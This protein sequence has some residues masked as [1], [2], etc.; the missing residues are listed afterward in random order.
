MNRRQFLKHA[1]MVPALPALSPLIAKTPAHPKTAGAAGARAAFRRVRPSDPGW[2]TAAQWDALKS[3]V[4]GRLISVTDPFAPCKT[5]PASSAACVD[6]MAELKNPFWLSETPGATQSAGWL[7]A[8]TSAPSVYAVA[9]RSAQDVAAAVNFAREHRLRFVVKGGGHSY[10]G[11]SNAPDSLLIWTHEMRAITLHDAFTPQGCPSAQKAVTIEAGAR[12]IEAYD[13]VTTKAG[14]YVQGGG[15]TTVGVVGLV[16]GGGFGSFSKHFGMA[17]ASLLEAEVVTADGQIRVANACTNPDLFW[18]LKGGGG[19]TF[20]VVTKITLAT[21]DLPE[22]AGG[23]SGA[24]KVKSDAAMKRLIEWF[25]PFAAK[26]LVNANWGESVKFDKD[27]ME[28]GMVSI[29]LSHEAT[30]AAWKPLQDFVAAAP[31]DYEWAEKIGGGATQ[32]R[33]WWDVDWRNKYTPGEFVPDPRPNM[34]KTNVVWKGDAPQATLFLYAY[35]S[36]WLPA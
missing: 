16:T 33:N 9:A 27:T 34:P 23:A 11:N 22:F 14:R 26:T 25:L 32:A 4:G 12:W 15:C 6:R 8:W 17:A 36:M 20:G 29:G 19:G 2:P 5:S 1:A 10:L 3:Q 7:D 24:I 13:A 30:L 35:E 18:A 21:H 28:F 31:S